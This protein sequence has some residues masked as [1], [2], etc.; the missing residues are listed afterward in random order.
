MIATLSTA[1]NVELWIVTIVLALFFL[2]LCI[3]T[4]LLIRVLVQIRKVTK[5]AESLI[6]SAKSA[7]DTLGKMGKA[8]RQNFPILRIIASIFENTLNR[9]K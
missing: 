8:S 1:N 7:A 2:L 5:R 4:V 6:N 9:N 3:F